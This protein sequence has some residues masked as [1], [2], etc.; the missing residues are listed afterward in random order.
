[1]Q[2]GSWSEVLFHCWVFVWFSYQSKCGFIEPISDPEPFFFFLVGRLLMTA[3]IPLGVMG[4]FRWF[5]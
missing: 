3:S 5:I 1:M 2:K 4:L